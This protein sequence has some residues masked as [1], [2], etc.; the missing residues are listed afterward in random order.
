LKQ[1][2]AASDSSN[3]SG[4]ATNSYW[5]Y[6]LRFSLAKLSSAIRKAHDSATGPDSIHY[7]MIKKLPEQTLDTLLRVFNDLW[8]TGNFPS[9]WSEATVIPFPKPVKYLTDP[10]NYRP[11]ALTSCLCKTFERIVNCRLLWFLENNKI[12][13]EYQSGF[14]KNRSTT[15]QLIRLESYIR[16]ASVSKL[17]SNPCNLLSIV[18]FFETNK[19]TPV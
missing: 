14:H 3:I 17:R 13:T 7:Q 2:P 15:D 9:S 5:P 12:L 16:E 19:P 1:C 6:N 10:G 11:N 4:L 8:V 18:Y